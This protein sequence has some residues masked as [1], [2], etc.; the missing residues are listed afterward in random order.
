MDPGGA[1]AGQ[2]PGGRSPSSPKCGA[3]QIAAAATVATEAVTT[4]DSLF[5]HGPYTN[6]AAV[7]LVGGKG[8]CLK[9]RS[10]HGSQR[11]PDLPLPSSG[12]CSETISLRQLGPADG[13]G[14]I[15]RGAT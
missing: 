2:V 8:I 14:Q 10:R 5:G 6:L 13:F 9:A 15:Y 11:R 12:A 3:F 4:H 1:G 7:F